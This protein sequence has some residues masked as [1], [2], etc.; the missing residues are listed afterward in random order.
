[1]LKAI[2]HVAIICSDYQRSKAF[3]HQL[4]KLPILAEHYRAERDSWKLD[5]QLPDGSQLEL[6]SFPSP[7]PRPNQPEAQGLRHL[8]FVVEDV[9]RVKA[10]LEQHGV[11]VEPIRIDPYTD[12]AFT[13][14]QDPDGL[15]LELY[16]A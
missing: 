16:Q 11:A 12:K 7:P 9:A 14:F 6:F 15:P 2:H 10:Y 13:F 4:L 8:A 5:L 1:M 3:Y